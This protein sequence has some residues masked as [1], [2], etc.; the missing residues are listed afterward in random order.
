MAGISSRYKKEKN[1]KKTGHR[2]FIQ[3][4]MGNH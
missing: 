2:D 4:I 3:K 1:P